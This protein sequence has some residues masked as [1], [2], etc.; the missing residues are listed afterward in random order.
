MARKA[1]KIQLG[2]RAVKLSIKYGT[3]E[4]V[5]FAADCP[6]KTADAVR[7]YAEYNDVRCID[8][9]YSKRDLAFALGFGELSALAVDDEGF[10]EALLK[11]L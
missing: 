3:A 7:T 11:L 4:I 10:A 9:P 6:E 8:L 2:V 5:F 1:R